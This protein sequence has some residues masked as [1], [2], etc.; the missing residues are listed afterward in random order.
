MASYLETE[1]GQSQVGTWFARA[2][3][4]KRVCN[5]DCSYETVGFPR[6]MRT[7]DWQEPDKDGLWFDCCKTAFRPYDLAVTAFLIIA[8]HHPKDR[9]K[10]SSDGEM[11]HWFDGMMVT[12]TYLGYGLDF[13]LP[14]EEPKTAA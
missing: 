8:K 3:I 2:V 13:K 11:Q 1:S 12:K 5:G 9:F 7:S 6:A 10:V 4:D 14:I